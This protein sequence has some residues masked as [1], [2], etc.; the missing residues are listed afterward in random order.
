[1]LNDQEIEV[2][3]SNEYYGLQALAAAWEATQYSED[4]YTS[5]SLHNGNGDAYRHIMWNALMKKYTTSTYAK[6]FAA[7]H[8][9]GSTGQPAIEKQMDLYNN[10]VGRGITLVGSNLEL[11]LDALAK[12]GSKVDDGYGKRISSTGTLIVT[13]STGKK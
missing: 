10:S 13:N 5:T 4:I 1:M 7:A 3:N 9:N 11:K 6:Q 8:E 12:V 2:F